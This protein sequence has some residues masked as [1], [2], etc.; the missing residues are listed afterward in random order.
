MYPLCSHKI[1][2]LYDICG[3]VKQFS[4]SGDLY[5]NDPKTASKIDSIRAS[6]R[7]RCPKTFSLFEMRDT[8]ILSVHTKFQTST[9]SVDL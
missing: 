4:K 6:A 9:T 2:D 5:K 3:C 1:S 7:A 8:G